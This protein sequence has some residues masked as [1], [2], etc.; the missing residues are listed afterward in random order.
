MFGEILC[1]PIMEVS[2]PAGASTT[3]P[4]AS[5]LGSGLAVCLVSSLLHN[6]V[7]GVLGG[8]VLA[9]WKL[10]LEVCLGQLLWALVGWWEEIAHPHGSVGD[11]LMELGDF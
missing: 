4:P 6:A 9:K 2:S 3:S 10:S 7:D 5:S 8:A 11:F 1:S